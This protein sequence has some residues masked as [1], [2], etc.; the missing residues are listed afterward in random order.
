M[1]LNLLLALE[2]F[3]IHNVKMSGE[4]ESAK[5]KAAEE[6]WEGLDDLIVKENYFPE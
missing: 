2:S 6:F 4:F 3:F 5:V 1:M